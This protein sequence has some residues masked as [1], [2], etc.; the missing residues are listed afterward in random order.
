M[1]FKTILLFVVTLGLLSIN[2]EAKEQYGNLEKNINSN[3]TGHS[4][5]LREYY[6]TADSSRKLY[7]AVLV[8]DVPLAEKLLQD[9]NANVNTIH[10]SDDVSLLSIAIM[11]DYVEMTRLLLKNHADPNIKNSKDE[12][13]LHMAAHSQHCAEFVKILMAAKVD[14]K[15]KNKEG[16]A[17]RDITQG[18]S[19]DCII[20]E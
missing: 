12:T 9:K 10:G 14:T 1:K 5:E 17:A 11:Q 15:V 19:S 2:V 18:L 16:K 6:E 8:N 7:L 13:A 4:A 20:P 3:L